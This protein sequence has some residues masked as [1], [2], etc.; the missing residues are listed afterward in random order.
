VKI[1]EADRP[2]AVETAGEA[3]SD[4][5]VA[6]LAGDVLDGWPKDMRLNCPQGT[7]SPGAQR[8]ICN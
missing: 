3:R 1:P 4:A 6:E 2:P 7:A 8:T 5:W